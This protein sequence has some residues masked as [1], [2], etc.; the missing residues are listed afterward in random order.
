MKQACP[1]CY[2]FPFDDMSSTFTCSDSTGQGLTYPVKF[3]DLK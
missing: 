2:T 3:S 1:T